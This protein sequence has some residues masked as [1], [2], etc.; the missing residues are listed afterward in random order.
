VSLTIPYAETIS[1][2]RQIDVLSRPD[3]EQVR[4]ALKDALQAAPEA[5][6]AWRVIV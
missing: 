3:R 4:Q 5:E 6:T 1:E 2:G